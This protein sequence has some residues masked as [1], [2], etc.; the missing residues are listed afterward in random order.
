M[1]FISPTA[2]GVIDYLVVV[3]LLA[4]PSMFGFTGIISYVTYAIAGV[5]F[6][7][8][9][10]TNFPLGLIKIIPVNVH[11]T[12]EALAGIICLV[13]ANTLFKGNFEESTLF[14]DIFGTVVLLTWLV[15]DYN[16][17]VSIQRSL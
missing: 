14:Y 7:L 9:I 17:P 6:L 11:A 15:T 3:F 2:H 16:R 13:L 4:A 1:K 8:T 12:I 5:H 10:L